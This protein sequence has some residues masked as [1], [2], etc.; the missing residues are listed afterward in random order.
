VWITVKCGGRGAALDQ[1]R[2]RVLIID[3]NEADLF[4]VKEALRREGLDCEIV[5]LTDGAQAIAFLCGVDA[6]A[7]RPDCIVLDL[8]LPKV[9]GDQ[10]LKAIREHPPM[11]DVPILVW[12]SSLRTDTDILKEQSG[13]ALFVEKPTELREFLA[14]GAKIRSLLQR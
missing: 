5:S 13:P 3:D 8:N 1:R 10:V 12:S 2:S 7:N 11:A 6:G 9:T 4:L 14:I